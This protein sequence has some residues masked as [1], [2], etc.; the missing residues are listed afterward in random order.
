MEY[1]A[2]SSTGP[3]EKKR[4][5][6]IKDFQD[7]GGRILQEYPE[8][9][10]VRKGIGEGPDLST[11]LRKG[12][13]SSSLGAYNDVQDFRLTLQAVAIPGRQ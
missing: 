8:P 13:D 11:G 1:P 9:E 2:K 7:H 10:I 12:N 6:Q 5:F 3:L 4:S